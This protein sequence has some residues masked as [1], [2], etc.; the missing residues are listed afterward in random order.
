MLPVELKKIIT[1]LDPGDFT[2]FV[3]VLL[4]AERARLAMP[5]DALVMSDALSENDGGLDARLVGVPQ[6]QPPPATLPFGTVGI[7][8][9]ATKK[10]GP[11]AF[12][13]VTELR[14]PGPKKLF[15][16]AGT[17]VLVSCQEFNSQQMEDLEDAVRLAA[18]TVAGEE[19]IST[20]VRTRV[21][22]A[23]TLAGLCVL[24]EASVA[25][26]GLNDFENAMSLAE[27]LDIALLAPRRAFQ[28][29]KNRE[30][31]IGQLRDRA[32][33][34]N[35]ALLMVVRGY[36]GVGKSRTVAEAL[37]TDEL[38]DHVLCLES[39]DGLNVMLNRMLRHDSSGG[40]LMLDEIGLDT[41]LAAAERLQGLDGRWRLVVVD[42]RAT[43][44]I[45]TESVSS[46]VL[47]PL[48]DPAMRELVREHSDLAPP[49][50]DRVAR[51]A[52]GYP[53][54]ALQLIAEIRRDPSLDLVDL[55]RLPQSNHLLKRALPDAETRRYLGPLALFQSVG[56]DDEVR[57]QMEAVADAFDLDAPTLELYCESERHSR[58]FVSSAGR[59]RFIS[60]QLVAIWLAVE[61][62]ENTPDLGRRIFGLPEPLR[63]SF[64][65]QLEYFGSQ[66][67]QL[68]R[69]LTDV[70][71]R[72]QFHDIS[73]FD[74]AVATLLRASAKIIPAQVAA[75]VKDVLAG[76]SPDE[77]LGLPR[78]ELVQTCQVLLWSP[79]CWMPAVE[80]LFVLA[81]H[82]NE[83]YA[84]NATAQ[85]AAAFTTVLSG[86]PVPY[87]QRAQWLRAKTEVA[88]SEELALL[89]AAAAAGMT[90]HHS[91]FVVGFPGGGEPADWVPTAQQ[92]YV[93]ARAA[94]LRLLVQVRDR[95]ASDARLVTTRR[96]A[97]SLRVAYR[98]SLSALVSELLRAREW[99]SA[100]RSVLATG[101]RSVLRF[102]GDIGPDVRAEVGRLLEWVLD[103]LD[104]GRMKVLLATPIWD[105]HDSEETIDSDPPALATLADEL[106]VREDGLAALLATAGNGC[107]RHTRWQFA[108]LLADRLGAEHVGERALAAEDWA[109]LAA[110]VSVADTRGEGA[111]ATRT[112]VALLL[113]RPDQAVELA[114]YVPPDAERM[115]AVLDAVES[116]RASGAPLSRM[117]IGG[118]VCRLQEDQALRLIQAV[119]GAGE[120]DAALGILV[121]WLGV[122]EASADPWRDLA[123]NLAI[124]AVGRA[125]G[126]MTDFY[127]RQLM[128]HDVLD[129]PRTLEV[130]DARIR[131]RQEPLEELDDLLTTKAL[132]VALPEMTSRI[133]E[134]VRSQAQEGDW[135]DLHVTQ[136]LGLLSRLA[137]AWSPHEVW[138]ELAKWSD[139]ELRFALYHMDW[140]TPAPDPV[141]ANFLASPRFDASFWREATSCFSRILSTGQW[142]PITRWYAQQAERARQWREVLKD[143]P[144]FN[145]AYNIAAELEG[146]I[147]EL[148]K[149][150][151]EYGIESS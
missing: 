64:V 118:R 107:D 137:K 45:V 74:G 9:K 91:R 108:R 24:H 133:L 6:D 33:G 80:A 147:A 54:L 28:T 19:G 112:L 105:L 44:E 2:A 31:V 144:G 63:A 38:R 68:A 151:E 128:A 56:F 138:N 18:E 65:A 87:A 47:L 83:T 84:N 14:K 113:C 26:F 71:A 59:H 78:R 106:A 141:V 3:E 129:G 34:S 145:W 90:A 11:S 110:A 49:D 143:T 94:A 61:A 126:P 122:S 81:S 27:L 100:E 85:F 114:D 22:D 142:G 16:E 7:Q 39:A 116:G 146:H 96:L 4:S 23:S 21:W 75:A 119:Q 1:R 124:D 93:D 8:V 17:Y 42:G 92:D 102:E 111:W 98:S 30:S 60:P 123:R 140:S 73:Q 95:A 125:G 70:I 50:V 121:Q 82:E 69:V 48:A 29:D 148:R 136:D 88:L 79:D 12:D 10:K 134:L 5:L 127:L 52:A 53:K 32:M 130:W 117:L 101:L 57:S 76:A 150:D 131:R 55:A 25:D 149:R 89:G 51:A 58:R 120:S 36:P 77:V 62:I 97:G 115:E 109:V 86:S 67:P 72:P 132:T 20:P 15:R 104:M 46:R 99:S 41:S 66:V 13:L 35:D 43:T 135:I 37:D 103:T 40:I 139:D